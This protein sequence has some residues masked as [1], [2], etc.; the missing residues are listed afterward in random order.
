MFISKIRKRWKKRK[1]T[2][3]KPRS[4]VWGR[5]SPVLSTLIF[6][7]WTR[8]LRGKLGGKNPRKST[9]CKTSS[10]VGKRT[11]LAWLIRSKA[12]GEK[13]A[14]SE[15]RISA[16]KNGDHKRT[17]TANGGRVTVLL[18]TS[19]YYVTDFNALDIPT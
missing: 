8:W 11:T 16:L 12:R 17:R 10:S 3:A 14:V 15:G 1:E 2:K 13:Q 9:A 6:S 18:Q 7:K 19:T 4:D 5:L